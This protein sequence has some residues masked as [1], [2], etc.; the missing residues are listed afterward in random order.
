MCNQLQ[1]GRDNLDDSGVPRSRHGQHRPF[2]AVTRVRIP[3]GTPIKSIVYAGVQR[4][5]CWCT[6]KIRQSYQRSWGRRGF[7]PRSHCAAGP[8]RDL[9]LLGPHLLHLDLAT[10]PDTPKS[11]PCWALCPPS[12][13]RHGG[14]ICGAPYRASCSSRRMMTSPHRAD[15]G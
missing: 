10:N 9:G 11:S 3:S 5:D 7:L 4:I 8:A 15:V 2:T 13:P 14:C 1:I 6:A 12:K